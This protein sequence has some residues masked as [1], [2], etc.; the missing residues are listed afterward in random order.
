M[1]VRTYNNASGRVR[2]HARVRAKVTGTPNRP[3]LSVFRSNAHIY[4]Q[5]IDD[6]QGST[7]LTYSDTMLKEGTG[8]KVER[9]RAV[10]KEIAKEAKTKNISA[11]VFD[12]GGFR[13]HGRV[14]ALAEGAREEGLIF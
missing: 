7:L 14:K 2:R 10:G 3:R 4:A 13:Y 9:A 11:I 6:A 12:R 5:L 1:T 8:T